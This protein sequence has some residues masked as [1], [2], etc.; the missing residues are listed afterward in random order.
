MSGIFRGIAAAVFTIGLL[1][2]QPL[3]SEA[4]VQEQIKKYEAITRDNPRDVEFW[5]EL[6][7][8]YRQAEMWDK[9]IAAE[10]QAVQRFPKYAAAFY[11]RGKARMGKDDYNGAIEDF[12]T[13][14][15]LAELRGGLDLYLT[16]EQPT[17]E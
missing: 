16:V 11:G 2:A 8:L 13:C 15:K 9:A 6:A 4:R 3:P 14:I 7:G 12:T 10:T 5:H 1:G 17:P